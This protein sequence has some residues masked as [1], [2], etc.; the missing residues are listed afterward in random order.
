[1]DT[2]RQFSD[3]NASL[4]CLLFF[5][6]ISF[7]NFNDIDDYNNINDINVNITPVIEGNI[8]NVYVNGIKI[9]KR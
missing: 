8:S 2:F 1:M 5:V 3:I 9:I 6:N 4:L 7:I